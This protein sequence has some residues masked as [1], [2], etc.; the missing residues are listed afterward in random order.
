MKLT[1][2]S[3][4]LALILSGCAT[5][6]TTTRTKRESE[7]ARPKEK[8]ALLQ[9]EI[10]NHVQNKEKEVAESSTGSSKS[11]SRSPQ[12]ITYN[13][14][15]DKYYIRGNGKYGHVS[16]TASHLEPFDKLSVSGTV[17]DSYISLNCSHLDPFDKTTISGD[18]DA[19]GYASLNVNYLS[20]L[21]KATLSGSIGKSYVNISAGGV[22]ETTHWTYTTVYLLALLFDAK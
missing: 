10:D 5:N 3:A 22:S 21:D 7:I 14:P 18:C 11:G 16:L 20:I 15:L 4:L 17:G 19:Y 13:E 9:S 6:P 1:L 8:N 2:I 12:V